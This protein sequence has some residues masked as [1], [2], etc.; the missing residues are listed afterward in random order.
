MAYMMQSFIGEYQRYKIIGQ[1][2]IEQVSDDALNAVLAPD[3]NS[4]AMI[5]RHLSGNFTSRFTDFLTSDGEKPWRDRDAEF[6]ETVYRREEVNKLWA[7]GWQV[8]ENQLTALKDS[9]LQRR[10]Q[11]RGQELTVHEA[12][13]RSLAHTAYHVGQIVLLARAQAGGDW[14]WISIPKGGSQEYNRNP[15][16]EKKPPQ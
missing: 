8:L 13:A 7:E 2:A 14:K 11:I 5:V 6:E 9:D 12:L 4:I 10:V 3:S 1:K 15:T 16:K